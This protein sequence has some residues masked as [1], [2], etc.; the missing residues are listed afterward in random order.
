[1]TNT[2]DSKKHAILSPSGAGKWMEC[3]AS[4]YAEIGAEDESSVYAEEGT[5][6]HLLHSCCIEKEQDAIVYLGNK[7]VINKGEAVWTNYQDPKDTRR[8]FVV[9]DEMAA[10][11][12]KSL[13]RVRE[14]VG[15]G[16]VIF[17]EQRLSIS[18]LTGE[19]DAFGTADVVIINT[20]ELQV[21]D[22]KYGRGV[23]VDAEMN[24]QLLIYALAAYDVYQYYDDFKTVR[25]VIHQPRLNHH[26]EF[27]LTVEE[28]VAFGELVKVKA[29][30]ALDIYMSVVEPGYSAGMH[31]HDYYCKARV[32]CEALKKLSLEIAAEA[33][34]AVQIGISNEELG[35]L[36][37]QIPIAEKYFKEVYAKVNSEV[38]NGRAVPGFKLVMGKLGDREWTDEKDVVKE[39]TTLGL[40]QD[41]IWTKK[42]ISPTKAGG[43]K[44][45]K[46]VDERLA[47]LTKRAPG[48]PAVAPESD[49]RPA[50][51]LTPESDFENLNENGEPE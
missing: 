50:I 46:A 33:E 8:Y 41:K 21:H 35:A 26:P 27:V 13:D 3:S 45:G 22:L 10:Q 7:I 44:L 34:L 12:Q 15:P 16:G 6:A 30:L 25:I 42:I 38:L 29:A 5:A 4:A 32:G 48:K 14:Y 23:V 28:L 51:E 37:T 40:T 11:V 39:L 18:H 2:A 17:G 43:L 1:M 31:C 49:K 19:E 36:A 47:A 9:D 20:D 24:K